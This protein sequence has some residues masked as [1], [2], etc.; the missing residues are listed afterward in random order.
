VNAE[1]NLDFGRAA[2]TGFS[3]VIYCPGKSDGQ[4]SLIAQEIARRREEESE[5]ESTL[6]SR[7]TPEQHEIITR[8]LPDAVFHERA[9]ITG[10]GTRGGRHYRGVAVVT[11]GSGDVPVAEEAAVTAEYM[12]CE[13]KRLYDV[14][15]AGIHRLLARLPDL[16][17]ARAIV[18]VAGMEGALPTVLGGLVSC[19]VIAVPTSVGY[20][21]N[22]GGVAPLLTMLNSCALGV[23]VVNIDN[24]IGG[25][26][27]AA[28]IVRQIYERQG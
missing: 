14:G 21:V 27:A 28:T 6:F 20:G 4:L 11:A 16:R 10:V 2:R 15:V 19:P 8:H 3:E 24:G 22:F 23:T 9:R 25:G 18:A 13:V 1:V 12:G 17:E 26:Y 7:V 5:N